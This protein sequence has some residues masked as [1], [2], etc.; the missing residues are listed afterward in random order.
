MQGK[1]KNEQNSR[2]YAFNEDQKCQ[3]KDNKFANPRGA[4]APNVW[5]L[6]KEFKQSESWTVGENDDLLY[7]CNSLM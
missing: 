2:G 5:V 3:I 1:E 4:I 6:S 7:L